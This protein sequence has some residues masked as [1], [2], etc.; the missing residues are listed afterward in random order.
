MEVDLPSSAAISGW[1]AAPMDRRG[2]SGPL[3]H[4]RARGP[5]ASVAQRSFSFVVRAPP[6]G[7]DLAAARARGSVLR[8]VRV[9]G[10]EVEGIT[11]VRQQGGSAA[12]FDHV[13]AV[14]GRST[15]RVQ[16][17]TAKMRRLRGQPR[18]RAVSSVATRGKTNV[19]VTVLPAQASKGDVSGRISDP[20]EERRRC[21]WALSPRSR[22]AWRN[23]RPT[24]SS[25]IPF[26]I[27]RQ[28]NE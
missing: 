23:S 26:R 19:S 25:S 5:Y 13:S 27:S 4:L 1:V 12:F 15:A 10:V 6:P 2:S 8:D 17:C 18:L 11:R 9:R 7:D 24:S 21:L 28:P 16:G 3:L 14:V 22:T 20:Q